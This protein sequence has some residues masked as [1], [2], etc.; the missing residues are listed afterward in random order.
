[1]IANKKLIEAEL[2]SFLEQKFPE[3][4]NEF[5]LVLKSADGAD[6]NS[7]HMQNL[8]NAIYYAFLQQRADSCTMLYILVRQ[9][10]K[11]FKD[12]ERLKQL[13][14]LWIGKKK[15]A[16]PIATLE[17]I[18]I[19]DLSNP[20]YRVGQ[21]YNYGRGKIYKLSDLNTEL[22]QAK[23]ELMDVFNDLYLQYDL[24]YSFSLP[25]FEK[26]NTAGLPDLGAKT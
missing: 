22:Q 10:A 20:G 6:I 21:T 26:G 12:S 14:N 24:H 5:E 7:A 13:S 11:A 15:D 25:A 17:L 3:E 16:I 23:T 1:M 4:C 9:F 18:I 8:V 19:R 2:N